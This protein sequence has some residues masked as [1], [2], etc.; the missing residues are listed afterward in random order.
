[1]RRQPFAA[2]HQPR[3][4]L[5]MTSDGAQETYNE[6]RSLLHDIEDTADEARRL[7]DSTEPG[8][9]AALDGIAE[10]SMQLRRNLTPEMLEDTTQE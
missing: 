3:R 5:L 9:D 2:A 7:L 10:T 4:V 6:L 1:M 8:A